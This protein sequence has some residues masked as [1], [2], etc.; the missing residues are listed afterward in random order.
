MTAE[1]VYNFFVNCLSL[2]VLV[3]YSHLVRRFSAE[4]FHPMGGWLYKFGLIIHFLNVEFS[5][6]AFILLN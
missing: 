3:D 2:A 6:N 4:S 5:G 1:A